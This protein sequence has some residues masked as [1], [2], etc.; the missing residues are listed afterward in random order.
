MLMRLM[1]VLM[2]ISVGIG[3]VFLGTQARKD[4][5]PAAAPMSKTTFMHQTTVQL[6]FELPEGLSSGSGVVIAPNLA[7]SASHVCYKGKLKAAVDYAKKARK[8]IK[9]LFAKTDTSDVCIIVGDFSGLPITKLAEYSKVRLGETA[10]YSGY[11]YRRYKVSTGKIISHEYVEIA[12]EDA[13]DRKQY[14]DRLDVGC[15]PGASGGPVFNSDMELIGIVFAYD[16]Y[17]SQCLTTQVYY[18]QRF[19]AI[20]AKSLGIQ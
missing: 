13:P 20:N 10:Y 17:G 7:V 15:E 12:L 18:I 11:P 9:Y 1:L 2:V 16:K 3:A 14:V 4:R 5:A 8:V 19:L 6:I